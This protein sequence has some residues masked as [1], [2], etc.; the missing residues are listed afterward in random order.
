MY[1][2]FSKTVYVQIMKQTASNSGIMAN[3]IHEMT[4][5]NFRSDEMLKHVLGLKS[6]D[7]E[8]YKALV[9]NGPMTAEKLGEI[10][11]RE[12][13]TAY[14]SLQN[15]LTCGIVYREVNS[16]ESGGYYYEY[17]AVELDET[18]RMVKKIVDEWYGRMN[19]LIEKMDA[20]GSSF[21]P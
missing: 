14:R 20:K 6:L 15:L 4:I 11:N 10:L 16:I 5:A 8:A 9:L 7:I 19:E 17:I 12:R 18:K 3:S 21:H 13:S 2:V 1:S